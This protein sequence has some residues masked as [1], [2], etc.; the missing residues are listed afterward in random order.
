MLNDRYRRGQMFG[1]SGH[2]GAQGID[3]TPRRAY[4]DEVTADQSGSIVTDAPR[5]ALDVPDAGNT[6]SDAKRRGL[7]YPASTTALEDA[8]MRMMVCREVSNRRAI[9]LTVSP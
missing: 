1:Q 7:L 4:R 3:P 6:V 2:E 5:Y 8:R 9:S